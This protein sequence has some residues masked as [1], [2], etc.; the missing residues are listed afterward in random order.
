MEGKKW[1]PFISISG[2]VKEEVVCIFH[3]NVFDINNEPLLFWIVVCNTLIEVSHTIFS[4]I[5][6]VPRPTT[7]LAYPI[8]HL[9]LEKKGEMVQNLCGKFIN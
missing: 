6:G 7:S 8:H 4:R 9:T 1:I 2:P 3:V 5:F